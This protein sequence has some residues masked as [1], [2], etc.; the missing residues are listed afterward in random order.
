MPRKCIPYFEFGWHS[1]AH[2]SEIIASSQFSYHNSIFIYWHIAIHRPENKIF[3]I[4]V[5]LVWLLLL[6]VIS[7]RFI[8]VSPDRSQKFDFGV[9]AGACDTSS[10][11]FSVRVRRVLLST[12]RGIHSIQNLSISQFWFPL[13]LILRRILLLCSLFLCLLPANEKKH[14]KKSPKLRTLVTRTTRTTYTSNTQQNDRTNK[15]KSEESLSHISLACGQMASS[16]SF[17][18]QLR[19]QTQDWWTKE[20]NNLVLRAPFVLRTAVRPPT[21]TTQQWSAYIQSNEMKSLQN[22]LNSIRSIQRT[23]HSWAH[24]MERVWRQI[25]GAGMGLRSSL[26]FRWLNSTLV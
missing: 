15:R 21:H 3:A 22:E 2:G 10:F 11:Q 19:W 8:V 24:T 26:K 7:V 20:G 14:R 17:K 1:D 25:D 6:A 9:W 13:C 4:F 23:P 16:L 18:R 12:R 5:S